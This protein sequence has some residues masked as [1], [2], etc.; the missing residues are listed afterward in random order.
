MVCET[1]EVSDTKHTSGVKSLM[2]LH[3]MESPH[4]P[5]ERQE[6]GGGCSASQ[7]RLRLGGDKGVKNPGKSCKWISQM[8]L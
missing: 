4:A 7:D 6:M 1:E 5:E 2:G 3:P 8:A